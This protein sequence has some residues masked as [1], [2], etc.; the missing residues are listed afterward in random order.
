MNRESSFSPIL[1][2]GNDK[3]CGDKECGDKECGDKE[4]GDK[5]CE[6]LKGGRAGPQLM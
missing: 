3:E 5:E 2:M 1:E 6:S 4:C